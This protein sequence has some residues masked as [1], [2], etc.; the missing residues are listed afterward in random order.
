MSSKDKIA[1]PDHDI[2][3][4]LAERYSPY[5]FEAKAVE[6]DKLVRCLEAARWSASSYNEQPW[7]FFLATRDDEAAWSAALECLVEPN[8]AWATNA[9]GLI[10]TATSRTF[11]RNG[12]P[13]RVAEHDI[14]LAA[15]NLCVQAQALGLHT[16]QMAGIDMTRCRMT[17]HIPDGFDPVTAIAIG[18]AA[19][20]DSFSDEE[21]AQ[22]DKGP[23]SRKPL[24]EIVFGS[25]FGEAHPIIA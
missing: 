21:L 4:V 17:Y 20:P 2:L 23:R 24:N 3:P 7:R 22:R 19:D 6:P 5:C 8:R 10:F 15:S 9:G 16:H 18:Y 11:S 13:N 14:G 12:K 1:S 25:R